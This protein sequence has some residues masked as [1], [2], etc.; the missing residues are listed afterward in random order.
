MSEITEREFWI[1]VRQALLMFIAAID[2]RYKM[3]KHAIENVQVVSDK[4][5]VTFR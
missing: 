4:D 2:R 5:S 1:L 3:G